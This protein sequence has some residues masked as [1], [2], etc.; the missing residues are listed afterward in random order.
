MSRVWPETT[1]VEV[2][3]VEGESGRE[4]AL[5]RR[6]RKTL[7]RIAEFLGF[8]DLVALLM[9]LATAFSAIATWRT[10]SIANALYLAAERPY[11]GVGAVTLEG[12]HPGDP[13]VEVLYRNDG[14]V[15][16]ENVM[17]EHRMRIDDRLIPAR[18]G[19]KNAG[20]LSPRE[21]HRIRLHIPPKA[22][23]G[24]IAGKSKLS[25]EIAANYDGPNHRRQ[26]CY[27][28]RFVYVADESA[29]EVDG[30]TA[31]CAEQERLEAETR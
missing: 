18:D 19:R 30:G 14:D 1:L 4:P 17:I 2:R 23:D 12:S 21:P 26:L 5:S 11:F 13:R 8:A 31:D 6:E 28:E 27:L 7:G 16:A 25:V 10:A 15:A 20:I 24:I 3:A 9:V 22:I 29:F